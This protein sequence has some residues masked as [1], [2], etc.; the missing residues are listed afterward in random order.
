MSAASRAPAKVNLCL[1][2]GPVRNDGRHELVSVLQSLSLH[3]RVAMGP[4]GEGAEDDEIVCD[5]VEGPNL[6]LEAL[7]AFR[8]AIG[9]DAPPQRI[10]IDKR[11]PV[12]GGMA[13]G[14]ADAAAV[15]R[16]AA[17]AAGIEER[18]LLLRVAF[19][20]G[21]DVPS[22]LEPGCALITGAGEK[23][24]RLP[25]QRCGVL[26]L[27][28]PQP[29]STAAVYAEADRLRLPLSSELLAERL[30]AVEEAIAG[31]VP[32]PPAMMVNELAPA[33]LSLMPAIA[34][35]LEEARGAGADA[36]L[37]SGSGP[38]VIGLFAGPSGER[39]A[40]RAASELAKSGRSPAPF[41][42]VAVGADFA[43][44]TPTRHNRS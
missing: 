10:E 36:A 29:L 40:K 4:A 18:R 16:L 19:A 43:D 25:L 41:A 21:A 23:V 13:G 22:Q 42:A 11:I 37:V 24:E 12:A 5:G 28:S 35:A 30:A 26:V 44:V 27:P 2:V 7:R 31:D 1:F 3:D 38:S 32:L 33:A 20:L 15:L 34:D 8:T 6:A 39:K 9:W 17:A 14:S